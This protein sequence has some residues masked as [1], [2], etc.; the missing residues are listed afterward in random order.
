MTTG[1]VAAGDSRV[2]CPARHTTPPSVDPV[3]DLSTEAVKFITA[4]YRERQIPNVADRISGVLNEIAT[5]GTYWQTRNEL[6]YG[7]KVAWRQSVRCIGRVRWAGLKV[8]DRRTVTTIDGI[9]SELTEHLR[10]ADNGGRIQS[11]ITVFAPDHPLAGPRA[12]VWNDQ[13]IRYCGWQLDGRVLGD[14]AQVDMTDAALRLGW[15][16]PAVPGRFD[17]LPWV[18]ETVTEDPTLVDVPR[19]LVREVALTHP[20]HAWFADLRLRWH[21]LPVIANMRLRIG[22]VD[23]SCAPFNGH[24]LADEI[25]TR[26]MGDVDRYNQLRAVAAGLGLD[27]RDES[28]LWREH[29]ALVINQAVL[30]SFQAAGVRISDP[31]AES[32]LF[33]RFCA[34]EERAGRPVYGD[35]SWINGSVGWAALHAVHHRYYDTRVPNPNFWPGARTPY[36]PE[37]SLRERHYLANRQEG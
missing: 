25:G 23:Y 9:A 28:T 19:E 3:E 15:R 8:R 36:S 6:T 11:V 27:T 7:A 32:D 34:A 33:M 17:L 37:P 12:R 22:G 29:A 13:L 16:P 26:N 5:T 21:A 1:S 20:R 2:G 14:P 35:W 24:Y 31:H 18:I 4:Y 30:H 10:I